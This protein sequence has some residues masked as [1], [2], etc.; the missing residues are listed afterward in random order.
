MLI[1]TGN[2][3][4][5]DHRKHSHDNDSEGISNLKSQFAA[6]S[7][8]TSIF[9][10]PVTSPRRLSNVDLFDPFT[11]FPQD[12][13]DILRVLPTKTAH[14]PDLSPRRSLGNHGPNLNHTIHGGFQHSKFFSRVWP[15]NNHVDAHPLPLPP[16]A[17]PPP[18]SPAQHQSSVATHHTTENF[19]SMKGQWLKGKLIGRGSFGSV[20]HATNLY[21]DIFLFIESLKFSL[22]AVTHVHSCFSI[23][24]T[25]ASC[26]MKE[27]DLFLDDPK[28]ADCIKQLD[29]VPLPISKYSDFTLSKNKN[30]STRENNI[31][32]I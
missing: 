22:S 3:S 14:S 20:Y 17:S 13:N 10:S 25:G 11:N 6:K 29:Q 7:A 16:R 23:R 15:E 32:P 28:S 12:F 26:A 1:D 24:E 30:T 27:V 9:S 2:S 5:K 8:P 4:C 21:A 19:H 31:M 18:Q